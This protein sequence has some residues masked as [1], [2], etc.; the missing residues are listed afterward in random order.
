MDVNLCTVNLC[1]VDAYRGFSV[2][3]SGFSQ[4]YFFAF[5]AASCMLTSRLRAPF[6]RFVA[7]FRKCAVQLSTDSRA[8][9]E[10]INRTR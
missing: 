9:C 7:N 8:I 1:T 2:L 4:T 10:Y 6:R 5:C 3:V